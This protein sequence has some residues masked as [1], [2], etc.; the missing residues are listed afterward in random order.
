[1]CIL[2]IGKIRLKG[3]AYCTC[4]KFVRAKREILRFKYYCIKLYCRDSGGQ[5]S[6][7][8]LLPTQDEQVMFGMGG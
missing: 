1:M 2:K 7:G 8:Q 4:M 6:G 3:R 5:L